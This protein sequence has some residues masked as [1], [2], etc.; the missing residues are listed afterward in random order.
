[1]LQSRSKKI[2]LATQHISLM[3]KPMMGIFHPTSIHSLDYINLKYKVRL[4]SLHRKELIFEPVLSFSLSIFTLGAL[5][6]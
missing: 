4:F 6:M 2:E 1:M 5:A 3:L